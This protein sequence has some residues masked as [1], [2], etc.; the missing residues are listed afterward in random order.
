MQSLLS[1]IL[2]QNHSIL[3]CKRDISVVIKTNDKAGDGYAFVFVDDNG[4]YDVSLLQDRIPTDSWKSAPGRKTINEI[5]E[6]G[7]QAYR[8]EECLIKAIDAIYEYW[9]VSKPD[10]SF[11]SIELIEGNEIQLVLLTERRRK[12]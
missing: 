12:G 10:Y 7:K 3:S 9:N 1:I 4:L 8:K 5:F 11:Y 2:E 6:S